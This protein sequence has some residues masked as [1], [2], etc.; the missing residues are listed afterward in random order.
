MQ[1]NGTINWALK[2]VD[3]YAS[4][5]TVFT[6]LYKD[7]N[8]LYPITVQRINASWTANVLTKVTAS[9]GANAWT[10]AEY[11]GSTSY[12]IVYL[13]QDYVSNKFIMCNNS[14]SDHELEFVTY[15]LDGS[16]L[17]VNHHYFVYFEYI[18]GLYTGI[19]C[20]GAYLDADGQ[21]GVVVFNKVYTGAFSKQCIVYQNTAFSYD[22]TD[23]LETCIDNS[24][25][26]LGEIAF[27]NPAWWIPA[28]F[29]FNVLYWDVEVGQVL[30]PKYVAVISS[31]KMANICNSSYHTLNT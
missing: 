24:A 28:D 25:L 29:S 23:F 8:T 3:Y 9:T 22:T 12:Y 13:F 5:V 20:A 7:G 17:P 31:I 11:Y 16:G 15:T 21:R 18:S 27:T 10:K 6:S 19:R 26:G 14:H 30:Y 1:P 2:Y 4:T